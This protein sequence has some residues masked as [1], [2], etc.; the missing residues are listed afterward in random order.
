MTAKI[1][2]MPNV[3]RRFF[4]DYGYAFGYM[5]L[6]VA[7]DEERVLGNALRQTIKLQSAGTDA[8]LDIGCADGRLTQKI[9]SRF[10]RITV[11]EP[12][13]L[14]FSLAESRLSNWSPRVDFR[15]AAFPE[16]TALSGPF[17]VIV[18]SHVLYHLEL[19]EWEKFFTSAANQLAPNGILIVVLWNKHSEARH[20]AELIDRNR[21]LCGAE[22]ILGPNPAFLI[23]EAKLRVASVTEV[24]PIIKVFTH[25][26]ATTVKDFLLGHA[27]SSRSDNGAIADELEQ[28]LLIHGLKN[29]QSIVVLKRDSE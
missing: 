27:T 5:A 10:H 26:M 1:V 2:H 15:N 28:G 12:N 4:L 7:A 6:S 24:T 14:L 22:D 13:S 19:E 20:L 17:D 11:F 18:A 9:G 3:G 23:G 16:P 25:S 8:L 21:W 29:S